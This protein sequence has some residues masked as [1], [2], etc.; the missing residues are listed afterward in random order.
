MCKEFQ[1]L[2][3]LR[4]RLIHRKILCEKILTRACCIEYLYTCIH[5]H[6]P[7]HDKKVHHIESP[8]QLSALKYVHDVH[9]AIKV[10][11]LLRKAKDKEQIARYCLVKRLCFEGNFE[12]AIAN[13]EYWLQYEDV[14]PSIILILNGLLYSLFERGNLKDIVSLNETID[15]LDVAGDRATYTVLIDSYGKM[16]DFE[17]VEKLLA[18]VSDHDIVPHYRSF[19]VAADLAL[20]K[21]LFSKAVEY[22]LKIE[23]THKENHD[24]FCAAFLSKLIANKQVDA[25]ESVFQD[26]KTQRTAIGE[27]T[28][29]VI[30]KYFHS[31]L[32]PGNNWKISTTSVSASGIC[33]NCQRELE[34][35]AFGKP[36]EDLSEYFKQL[37]NNEL[38]T[39]SSEENASER[40]ISSKDRL[41]GLFRLL[42]QKGE[43]NVVVDGLNVAMHPKH[44]LDFEPLLR[45]VENYTSQGQK[46]LVIAA[47]ELINP[48]RS[49]TVSRRE[50]QKALAYLRSISSVHFVKHNKS[51]IDDLFLIIATLQLCRKDCT[52]KLVSNDQ[53]LDHFVNMKPQTSSYFKRWLSDHQ[54]TVHWYDRNKMKLLS[55]S[56][57]EF[58]RTIQR[59]EC[60]WHFPSVDE[61][62]WM[63]V[64][65]I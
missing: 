57:S 47:N 7:G 35:R 14:T 8:A 26:F 53:F 19:I 2:M 59:T 22:F 61:T 1:C 21:M 60:S 27:Q 50:H 17:K 9:P 51:G 37:I 13:V 41:Q 28:M 34:R 48:K 56:V 12:Q 10:P 65:K 5:Q 32:L 46:V 11:R 20:G 36:E 54:V 3:M 40:A 42:E 45:L 43:F 62:N 4:L 25:I 63:C 16:N 24:H 39:D 15:K 38:K 6:K 33:Q 18:L 29:L 49:K 44:G 55:E 23:G 52:V 31:G 64:E 30:E 58:A